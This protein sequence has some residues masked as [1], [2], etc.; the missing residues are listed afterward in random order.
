MPA[1]P[2]DFR[3]RSFLTRYRFMLGDEGVSVYVGA[4]T[5]HREYEVAYDRISDQRITTSTSSS[6]AFYTAV[7]ACAIGVFLAVYA[8]FT[9]EIDVEAALFWLFVGFFAGAA[10]LSSRREFVILH[11]VGAQSIAFVRRSPSAEAVD[12]FIDRLQRRKRTYLEAKFGG[13][14]TDL[15][16]LDAL[17]RLAWLRDNG[18]I[19]DAELRLIK[20]SLLGGLGPEPPGPDLIH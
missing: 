10:F 7:I 11:A 17:T 14:R 2:H 1:D 13:A 3:Q 4:I 16:V 19:D 20:V 6:F 5:Y 12:E 18:I 8:P 15:T 9:D